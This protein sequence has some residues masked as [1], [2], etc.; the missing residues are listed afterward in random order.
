[1][2]LTKQSTTMS[3]HTAAGTGAISRTLAD[4]LNDTSFNV[5]NY[6]ALGSGT[7]DD[8]AAIKAAAQAARDAGGGIVMIPKGTYL[9]GSSLPLHDGVIYEGLGSY[10]TKVQATGDFPVFKEDRLGDQGTGTNINNMVVSQAGVRNLTIQGFSTEGASSH[11][12]DI[13]LPNGCRFENL[14]IRN[15]RYGMRFRNAWQCFVSRVRTLKSYIGY[16]NDISLPIDTGVISPSGPINNAVFYSDTTAEKTILCGWRMYHT[17][18]SKLTA[19]EALNGEYG[20]YIGFDGDLAAGETPLSTVCEFLD[21][22]G[23]LCD[24]NN[25]CGIVIRQGKSIAV[26][27]MHFSNC[28]IGSSDVDTTVT[29]GQ[30]LYIENARQIAISGGNIVSTRSSGIHLKGSQTITVSGVMI[31]DHS[32][33]SDDPG[34]VLDNS[35][36]VSITGCTTVT[37]RS[38]KGIAETGGSNYN[39]VQGNVFGNGWQMSGT[40]SLWKHT[41]LNTDYN[42]NTPV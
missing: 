39:S 9:V 5:K 15:C 11:G 42:L 27:R 25:T 19:C 29:G 38:G 18:G 37:A 16:M 14:H 26:R 7:A 20:L 3:T 35:R 33:Y 31:A 4:A 30:G 13:Q 21:V 10:A 34:I 23:V 32:K 6:G 1:M 8:A 22:T 36:Y 12:V 2:G 41:I 28:W 40:G 24:T 17:Q